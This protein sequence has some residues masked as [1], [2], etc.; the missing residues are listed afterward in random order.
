MKYDIIVIGA[1]SGGLHIANFMSAL[2]LKVLL[3]EKHLIGGDSLN[4]GSVPSKALISIAHTVD[5]ARKAEAFGVHALSSVDMLKVAARI[6][7]RQDVVRI[8]ENP[9]YLR[10]KGID[11]L[12]GTPYFISAEAV[13][14]NDR[15]YT[16]RRIV[17]AT[18]S[19]PAVPAIEGLETVDYLTSET[20]FNNKALPG[21]LLVI[22]AGPAGIE[23]AQAYRRLG[24]KV[25]VVDIE[26]RILPKEDPDISET[27]LTILQKEGIEFRLGMKPLRFLNKKSL[28]IVSSAKSGVKKEETLFF[29]RVLLAAGR[30]LN[31]DGLDLD[32]AG[33]VVKNNK[34]LLDKFLRTTNKRVYCCGDAAGDFR[35]T[36][37]AEYQASVVIRN[38]VCLFKKPVNRDLAAW[39][40]YTDPEVAT[41]G[42]WSAAMDVRGIKYQTVTVPLED[43]DRAACEGIKEGL[44]KLFIARGKIMGGT[45]IARNAGEIVGE[46]VAFAALKIP[47]VRLY[48]RV[49]PYPTLSRI[50]QKAVRQFLGHKLYGHSARTLKLI[51]KLFNR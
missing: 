30:K 31:I 8:H 19:R 14:V 46:L 33:I 7:E 5:C 12:I 51:Y 49:Y 27:L 41:F 13:A 15:S 21:K 20:I 35:F 45:L 38:M 42:L 1:G 22:G 40:T 18:G 29:D 34:I 43:V 48:D 4:Y 28:R 6:K 47:F 16:A 37:W 36:H 9:D 10:N 17:I 3:V 23:I 2:R 11:V 25:I 50:N 32:T 24:S 39:V 44:L 26:D